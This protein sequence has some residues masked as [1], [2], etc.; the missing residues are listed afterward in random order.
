MHQV[1]SRGRF[2]EPVLVKVRCNLSTYKNRIGLHDRNLISVIIDFLF[3]NGYADER[4]V[5]GILM[6][7]ESPNLSETKFSFWCPLWIHVGRI[8]TH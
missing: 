2:R 5:E 7:V 1:H 6:D 3:G 4:F 8:L